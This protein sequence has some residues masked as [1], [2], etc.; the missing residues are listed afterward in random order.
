MA[1]VCAHVSVHLCI[2]GRHAQDYPGMGIRLFKCPHVNIL[3]PSWAR[4]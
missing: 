1:R 2:F 4:A 3:C